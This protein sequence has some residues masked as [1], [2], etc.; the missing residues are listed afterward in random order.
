MK[1]ISAGVGAVLLTASLT[2]A[3]LSNNNAEKMIA[4]Q[5]AIVMK[6]VNDANEA[7]ENDDL[8]TAKKLAKKA[9]QADPNNKAG[10]KAYDE[11]LKTQYQPVDMGNT[12]V[13]A[14][15]QPSV[16]EEE[17]EDMGC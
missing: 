8:K 15:V 13:V 11:V 10:F 5:D 12:N 6:Y 9:I 4:N 7:L 16:E 2:L 14:P 17:E 1:V 3:Y